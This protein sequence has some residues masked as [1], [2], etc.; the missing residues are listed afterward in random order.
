MLS[1]VVNDEY[2]FSD[3]SVTTLPPWK[4]GQVNLNKVSWRERDKLTRQLLQLAQKIIL[5]DNDDKTSPPD[6]SQACLHLCLSVM[7]PPV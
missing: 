5:D 3:Q 4:K 1:E 6:I 7:L 2:Y